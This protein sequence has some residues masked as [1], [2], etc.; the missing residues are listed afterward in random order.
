M[1]ADIHLELH[2]LRAADLRAAAELRATAAHTPPRTPPRTPLRAHVGWA[3][4][5]LGL[6]LAVPAT[7]RPRPAL[8]A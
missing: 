1:H 2:R 5:A 4:V 8:T 7:A 6:R 3:L